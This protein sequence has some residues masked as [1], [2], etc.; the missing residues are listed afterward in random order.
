MSVSRHSIFYHID[1]IT[2]GIINPFPWE[3][4]RGRWIWERGDTF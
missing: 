1:T 2:T 3:N 4:M